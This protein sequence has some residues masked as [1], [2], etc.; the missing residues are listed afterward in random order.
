M[1]NFF[2]SH[3]VGIIGLFF[4]ASALILA[5]TPPSV[6]TSLE[7]VRQVCEDGPV[8]DVGPQGEPGEQGEPGVQGLCGP[9]GAV[10]PAGEEGPEGARGATGAQGEQGEPGLQGVQG[11]Q[12]IQ[13]EIGPRGATGPQGPEGPAAAEVSYTVG[14][15]TIGGTQP[16]FTGAPMF[17]GSSIRNGDLVFVRINVDFDNITNF[18]TG[19]YYVTV[20]YP[21]KYDLEI[22]GGYIV[23]DNK[24]NY[25]MLAGRLT[26]GST[27]MTLWRA[28]SS[29][30]EIF[31]YN[32]PVLL[33]TSDSFHIS[34]SYI[35]Q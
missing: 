24:S 14:G 4:G 18:G 5:M 9:E 20:P 17:Y 15:G 7:V 25:Y 34:G 33:T 8:G 27:Q 19:Q 35:A 6:Q 22:R 16:T 13:G 3:W 29:Q 2:R 30:D 21:S 28:T 12:G 11:P 32:S 26:A 23:D 31:D 1:T 10:G